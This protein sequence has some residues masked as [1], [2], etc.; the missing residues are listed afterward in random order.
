M[1]EIRGVSQAGRLWTW[2]TPIFLRV[3]SR[4]SAPQRRYGRI[5]EAVGVAEPLGALAA[6]QKRSIEMDELRLLSDEDCGCRG[7]RGGSHGSHHDRKILP[8]RFG[9]HGKRFG[10]SSGLV[11]FYVHR[12][13]FS[14]ERRQRSAVAN[15][16]VRADG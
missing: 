8:L 12:V 6:E 16:L 10:Q 11:E 3:P 2:A 5:N 4:A 15:A 13:V 9:D 14:R 7:K 1:N